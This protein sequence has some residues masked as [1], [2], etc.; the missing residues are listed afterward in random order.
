VM[1]VNADAVRDLGR[2]AMSQ[3][4]MRLPIVSA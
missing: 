2:R 4:L 1:T 3:T